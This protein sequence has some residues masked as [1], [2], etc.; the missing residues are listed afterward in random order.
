M[1]P[2]DGQWSCRARRPAYLSRPLHTG[3]GQAPAPVPGPA[4][5]RR[6]KTSVAVP[7]PRQSRRRRQAPQSAG[8]IS[9]PRRAQGFRFQRS[10]NHRSIAS[11]ESRVRYTRTARGRAGSPCERPTVAP[12]TR[13]E[14]GDPEFAHAIGQCIDAGLDIRCVVDRRPVGDFDRV[15]AQAIADALAGNPWLIRKFGTGPRKHQRGVTGVVRGRTQPCGFNA[16][17]K[18][19]TS[20]N[21][22]PNIGL[23]AREQRLERPPPLRF[24]GESRFAVG[25]R[26]RRAIAKNGDDTEQRQRQQHLDQGE[27]V[28]SASQ[29]S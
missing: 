21:G 4:D 12:C 3:K 10:V 7:Q 8:P 25:Q 20:W 11:P 14:I 22:L 17:T 24:G 13:T 19:C 23:K 27:A 15:T 1:A 28:W 9:A 2:P 5:S 29:N 6:R 16:R 18:S 26:R